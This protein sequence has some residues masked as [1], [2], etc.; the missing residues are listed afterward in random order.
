MGIASSQEGCSCTRASGTAWT[1]TGVISTPVSQHQRPAA[2]RR[3][4]SLEQCPLLNGAAGM[5]FSRLCGCTR[6]HALPRLARRVGTAYTSLS[7][8]T[9][10]AGKGE[11]DQ[12]L[13]RLGW[14]VHPGTR[15]LTA[16]LPREGSCPEGP[17]GASAAPPHRQPRAQPASSCE[18]TC[19]GAFTCL[20][21][22][23]PSRCLLGTRP[24][25]GLGC[26]RN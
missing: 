24:R 2:R 17:S 16:G 22:H 1:L 18:H 15:P 25:S 11:V 5:L 23:G 26:C 14:S 9:P 21:A 13:W 10:A 19:L 6:T 20:S 7:G 4:S 12:A 3:G 8:T